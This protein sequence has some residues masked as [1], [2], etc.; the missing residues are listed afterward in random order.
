MTPPPPGRPVIR[1]T[2]SQVL[3][4]VEV[5]RIF[6][7]WHLAGLGFNAPRHSGVVMLWVMLR[8]VEL[9]GN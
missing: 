2:L 1:E 7:R 5:M 4:D 9:H 8:Q 6:L 3:D